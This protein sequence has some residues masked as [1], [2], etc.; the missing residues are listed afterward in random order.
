M[1]LG[2]HWDA[3]GSRTHGIQDV[4]G[5]EVSTVGLNRLLVLENDGKTYG[6]NYN[7]NMLHDNIDYKTIEK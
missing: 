6:K 3:T 4:L 5:P 2:N 1:S 7:I